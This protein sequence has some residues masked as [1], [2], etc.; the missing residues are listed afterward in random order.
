MDLVT[1]PIELGQVAVFIKPKGMIG[2]HIV[3]PAGV[4]GT[5]IDDEETER[6]TR[7]Q[8]FDGERAARVH[9]L[10]IA[11]NDGG[12]TRVAVFIDFVPAEHV[13]FARAL[14]FKID[15]H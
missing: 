13:V 3:K 2:W 7:L 8:A 6:F 9:V 10:G 14:A 4:I 1:R 12:F 11:P 5:V 15:G